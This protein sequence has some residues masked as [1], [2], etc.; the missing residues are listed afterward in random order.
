[1]Q[2]HQLNDLKS[3]LLKLAVD[4]LEISKDMQII[5][6]S[7]EPILEFPDEFLLHARELE[8][9]AILV[10]QWIHSLHH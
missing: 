6:K 5:N 8:A 9:A 2:Y 3:K 1:M 7:E 4:M 10:Q